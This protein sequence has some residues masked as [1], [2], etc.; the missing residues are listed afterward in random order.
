[1]VRFNFVLVILVIIFCRSNRLRCENNSV[2][3][4]SAVKLQIV[5][6]RRNYQY[7]FA[8]KVTAVASINQIDYFYNLIANI[9]DPNAA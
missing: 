4:Q 6:S 8:H 2:A 9:Y 1:M 7:R 5:F 3:I